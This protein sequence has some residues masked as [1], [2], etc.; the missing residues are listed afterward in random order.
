MMKI[1]CLKKHTKN[2]AASGKSA[3]HTLKIQ[4]YYVSQKKKGASCQTPFPV[5][6]TSLS[7]KKRAISGLIRLVSEAN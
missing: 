2:A 3:F 4:K 6:L 5:F 7:K 1:M